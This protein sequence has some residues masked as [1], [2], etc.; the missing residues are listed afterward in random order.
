MTLPN[1]LI[2]GMGRSGTTALVRAL[3]SHP[4]AWFVSNRTKYEM[5]LARTHPKGW[6]RSKFKAKMPRDPHT[7]KK[8]YDMRYAI[9]LAPHLKEE[10]KRAIKSGEDKRKLYMP[11]G[12]R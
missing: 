6:S 12:Q 7:G 11:S 9:P 8:F 10:R 4:N 3:N 1:T 5:K 2:V